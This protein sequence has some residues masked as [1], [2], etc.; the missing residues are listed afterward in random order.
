MSNG[1]KNAG[2]EL[3]PV[4]PGRRPSITSPA[5]LA[6]HLGRELSASAVD[7]NGWTDLHYAAALDWPAL[8]RA[9][10]AAGAPLDARLRTD[11][12]PLDPRLLRTLSSCGQDEFNRLLRTGA[13]PLHIASAADA[14]EVVAVLLEGGADPDV[15]DA[16]S[17]TPLHYAAAGR[18]GSAAAVLAEGGADVGA[19]TTKGVTPLHAAA[20]RDAIS[21]VEVLLDHGANPGAQDR[22]GDTRCI[23]PRRATRRRRRWSCSTAGPTSARLRTTVCPPCMS[24][25]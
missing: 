11:G 13:T 17:A 18:S 20:R 21:V 12:E 15:A 4:G 5:E 7:G 8:A 14:C 16:T 1:N 24:R 19:A 25:R 6:V 10:L 2:R 23:G 3:A 9:L 22:G